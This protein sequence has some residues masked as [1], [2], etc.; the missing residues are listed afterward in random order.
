MWQGCPLSHSAITQPPPPV[1]HPRR[2]SCSRAELSEVPHRPALDGRAASLPELGRAGTRGRGG[3]SGEGEGSAWVS[4]PSPACWTPPECPGQARRAPSPGW[5]SRD[6]GEGQTQVWARPLCQALATVSRPSAGRRP[7]CAARARPPP[8]RTRPRTAIGGAGTGCPRLCVHLGTKLH[9]CLGEKGQ[10]F[11]SVPWKERHSSG[12][13]M[14][15]S[16]KSRRQECC[17]RCTVSQSSDGPA[18]A[19]CFPQQ[20]ERQTH[21]TFTWNKSSLLSPLKFAFVKF[22]SLS[23][24][25]SLSDQSRRTDAPA[26]NPSLGQRLPAGP[27]LPGTRRSPSLP[28]VPRLSAGRLAPT[29]S[30][31]RWSRR[32][33]A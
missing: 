27:G 15:L 2:P 22:R 18:G 32:W 29:T 28:P 4:R 7:R 25:P 3:P 11:N 23:R 13:K 19:G 21:Y 17:R 33:A 8:R 31:H 12:D 9:N 10:H 6:Q 1:P 5:W 20:A 14:N 30:L 26:I 16:K 24:A